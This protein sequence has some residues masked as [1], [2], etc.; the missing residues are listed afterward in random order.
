MLGSGD[1]R[2]VEALLLV[3]VLWCFFLLLAVVELRLVTGVRASWR[4]KQRRKV[5][6]VLVLLLCVGGCGV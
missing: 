4:S 3:C 5:L 1:L 6:V 2:K